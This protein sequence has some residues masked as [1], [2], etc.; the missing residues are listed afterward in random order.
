MTVWLGSG[1]W[2]PPDLTEIRES[3]SDLDWKRP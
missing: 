1:L 3:Q 2:L